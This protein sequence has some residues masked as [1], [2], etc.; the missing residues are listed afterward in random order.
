MI[1][2]SCGI[3][4]KPDNILSG[5][6]SATSNKTQKIMPSVAAISTVTPNIVESSSSK[7]PSKQS[8]FGKRRITEMVGYGYI[9]GKFSMDDYVNGIITIN[10]NYFQYDIPLEK[11][12]FK[13]QSIK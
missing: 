2:T 12:N 8:F 11:K 7:F 13:N 1:I 3:N 9:Y 10:E 4:N 6:P 5:I